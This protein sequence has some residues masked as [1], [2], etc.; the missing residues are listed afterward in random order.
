MRVV[1]A[2]LKSRD[3]FVN[4]DTIVGG[5][6]SRF[7]GFSWTTRL[8]ERVRKIYQNV[9]SIH[10]AYVAAILSLAG[11]EVLFTD[12][13][14]IDG[15]VG[16]VLSS[17]VDYRN[18]IRWAEKARQSGMRVGFFGAMASHSPGVFE[19]HADFVIKGEP[20]AA[21]QRLAAGEVPAGHV[22]SLPIMR[23]DDL[24]FPAWHLMVH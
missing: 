20:E 23:L 7:R 8:I 21:V 19:N 14:L 5:F 24:P 22:Q 2:D 4:K 6:G 1:I 13:K 17:I 3:G 11:H 15:D 18:E 16:L 12:E 9:P 10:S